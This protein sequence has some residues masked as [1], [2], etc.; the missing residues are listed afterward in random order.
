[1]DADRVALAACATSAEERAARRAGFH[2]VRVGLG[3]GAQR[4][5]LGAGLR[6]GQAERTEVLSPRATRDGTGA[7]VGGAQAQERPRRRRRVPGGSPAV[8]R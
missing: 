4:P 8:A 1:M 5:G 3:A 2:T 7:M 6:L